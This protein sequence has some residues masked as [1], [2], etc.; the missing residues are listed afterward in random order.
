MKTINKITFNSEEFEFKKQLFSLINSS[1]CIV[2]LNNEI[3]YSTLSNLMGKTITLVE[4]TEEHLERN[5]FHSYWNILPIREYENEVIGGLY[6]LHEL[7]HMATNIHDKTKQHEF[8]GNVILN[9][10]FVSNLT[11][12]LIYCGPFGSELRKNSYEKPIIWDHWSHFLPSQ[13]LYL[14]M[15]WLTEIRFYTQ[16]HKY[17]PAIG[18]KFEGE[19]ER[20]IKYGELNDKFAALAFPYFRAAEEKINQAGKNIDNGDHIELLLDGDSVVMRELSEEL[21]GLYSG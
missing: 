11:E 8:S 21:K 19:Y 13:N 12:C 4:Y 9:E 18:T 17:N 3:T 16:T 15:I 10:R 6:V 14:A 1:V 7:L 2:A 5:F 20:I